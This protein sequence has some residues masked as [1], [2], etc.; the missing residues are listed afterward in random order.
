MARLISTTVV[1]RLNVSGSVETK[2]GIRALLGTSSAIDLYNWP[3][4]DY[5]L[6]VG[7]TATYE[8]SGAVGTLPLHIKCA[9]RR[10]YKM[11]VVQAAPYAGV[12]VDLGLNPNGTTYAGQFHNSGL[13]TT[14]GVPPT[15][16]QYDT[17]RD[18]FFFDDMNGSAAVPPY[19]RRMTIYVDNVAGYS[20]IL[21]YG[22]GGGVTGNAGISAQKVTWNS[23]ATAWTSLGTLQFPTP[24]TT[25]ALRVLVTRIA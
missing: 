6:Q 19:A 9:A 18:Y 14:P 22:G 17:T 2:G 25:N 10:V 13:I 11:V 23:T 21:H 8:T 3:G 12:N 20:I 16:I 1:G 15:I 4:A 7:Q 24:G 5:D